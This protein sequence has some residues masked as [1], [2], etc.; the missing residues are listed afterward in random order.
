[1]KRATIVVVIFAAISFVMQPAASKTI[2][3]GSMTFEAP[4]PC[5]VVC[6]Y[7]L[8]IANGVV[9]GV[10]FAECPAPFPSGSYADKVLTAPSKARFLTLKLYPTADWDMF[11]CSKPKS[12]NNGR[13]LK[14]G[15]NDVAGDCQVGCVE[16]IKYSVKPGTKYVVRAYN[17]SDVPTVKG[18]YTFS[19]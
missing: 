3:A 5:T 17:W 19:R 1:M 9:P 2:K 12:G 13:L 14:E 11:L 10:K 18:R 6:A 15:A 7:W 16:T 4:I 8:D